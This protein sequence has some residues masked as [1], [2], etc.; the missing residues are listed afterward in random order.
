MAR[1]AWHDHFTLEVRLAT[2]AVWSFHLNVHRDAVP[3]WTHLSVVVDGNSAQL[4]RDGNE[5]TGERQVDHSAYIGCY[6]DP[7]EADRDMTG[8]I[9]PGSLT[10]AATNSGKDNSAYVYSPDSGAVLND[11]EVAE[12]Q[13]LCSAMCSGNGYRYMGLQWSDEC[14]CGDSYGSHGVATGCG[15]GGRNCGDGLLTCGYM[16]AVFELYT[17][18][19]RDA[20]LL[21]FFLFL[22]LKP[23]TNLSLAAGAD[24]RGAGL[25]GTAIVGA[26]EFHRSGLHGTVAMF[27]IYPDALPPGRTRC[28]YE[29]GQRLVESGRLALLADT[30]CRQA[31]ATG[32]TSEAAN[33]GP[34]L[35]QT[36]AATAMVDDNSCSFEHLES[37]SS[38]RGVVHATDEWQVI[39][40]AGSYVKPLV[41]CGVMSR[42]STAQVRVHPTC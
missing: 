3:M 22:F 29:G 33:N 42:S 31:A 16:N 9:D 18:E 7:S 2:A 6:T 34:E 38:E 28:V 37:V 23:S 5:V 13:S 32:C 39:A 19:G 26:T 10:G 21:L 4:Y 20:C 30:T 27:Q 15:D 17:G 25:A 1:E 41:F 24:F 14:Y 35:G 12:T 8:T 11:V 36:I 40:L